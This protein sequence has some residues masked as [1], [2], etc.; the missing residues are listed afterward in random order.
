MGSSTYSRDDYDARSSFRARTGKPTFA[1]HDAVRTGKAKGVHPSLDPKGVG[2][3]ESRDSDAH[4]I[5]IPIAMCNDLTGSMMSVPITLQ[6][7]E[8][9]L[10]GLFLKDRAAGKKYL[11]N[12]YPAIMVAGCDDYFAIGAS[13]ALQVGQF[14]SGIEIDD[15]LTNLWLTGEG[16]GNWGESYDLFLYFL[17]RHTA[18]DH[19]DKRGRKGYA[20]IICDEPLFHE[21]DAD[22]VEEVIG[23]KLQ[24]DIPIKQII[25][26]VQARYH[27]FC[28]IP[29]QTSHYASTD[30]RSGW[31]RAIGAQNVLLLDD[32][33]KICELIVA[34]VAMCEGEVSFQDLIDDGVST[35]AVKNALVPLSKVTESVDRYSTGGLVAVPG[36]AGGAER[37]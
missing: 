5:A 6:A 23:D 29:N 2:I 4:P 36:D 21:V 3:R 8:P 14:E 24:A 35:G 13:G 1:Y 10:M 17:A 20:F 15:N 26:E 37:I 11:G 9:E 12:G 22:A 27:L 31:K 32:P 28:I 33:T 7:E 25:S 19:W 18:H 16:G 30:L 34:T